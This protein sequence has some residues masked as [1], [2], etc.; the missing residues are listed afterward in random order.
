M[1]HDCGEGH[2]VLD[3]IAAVLAMMTLRQWGRRSGIST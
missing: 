1:R 2:H 3:G